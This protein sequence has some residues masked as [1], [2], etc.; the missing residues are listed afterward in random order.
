MVSGVCQQ[1]STDRCLSGYCWKKR[2]AGRSLFL[3]ANGRSYS[4][5]EPDGHSNCDANG[6][7]NTKCD[8]LSNP[9]THS[10]TNCNTDSKAYANTQVSSNPEATPNTATLTHHQLLS[11]R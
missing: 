7:T 4:H 8:P 3:R 5:T 6:Y 11:N 9:D 1:H 10:Y 2:P